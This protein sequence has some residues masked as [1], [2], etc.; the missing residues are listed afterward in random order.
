MSCDFEFVTVWRV[1]GTVAEVLAVLSDGRTLPRWWPSVYLDV[2]L[3]ETGDATDHVGSV[4]DLHTKGWLPYTLR[5]SLTLTEPITPTGFAL[6]AAGDLNGTGRWTFVQDGPEVVITYDWRVSAAKPLLRRFSWLLRPAFAANHRWAMARGEES[7]RL[8]VRRRRATTEAERAAVPPPP[9]PTFT[10]LLP[11]SRPRTV[12]PRPTRKTP[13]APRQ[14][15]ATAVVV[16]ASMAGLCAARVLSERF[17]HVLVLD[18][19]ALPE[20]P[21]PRGQVPQGRHPHLLLVAGARL[22]EGWFPGLGAELLA[23]GATDVDVCAD[24]YWHQSGGVSRRPVS[25]L[26]GPAMSRPFLEHAVRRRVESLPNVTV[27]GKT[28][29]RG[30]RLDP[31]GERITDV[32]LADGALVPCGLVIDATGRSARS[33]AWLSDLGFPPPPVS[34]VQIDTRYVSRMYSRGA[35]LGRDWKAAAVIDDPGAKRMAS[36]FPIEGDRALVTFAGLNGAAP[37]IEEGERRAWARSLPSP[38]VAEF[39]ESAEPLGA[40]VTHRFP[41]N[42]RRRVER[43]RRFPLGWLPLGDA[44]CSFDP[45]YGQGMSSAALQAAAMARCLDRAVAIDGAFARRY[46]RA[47]SRTVA[48]PWSIAVGADFLYDGTTGHKPPGTDLLNRYLERARIAAQHDDAVAIGMVEVFVL[49]RPPSALVRPG[50]VL[51][52]LR[53]ARRGPVGTPPVAGVPE[54]R[55]PSTRAPGVAA[56]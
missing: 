31:A 14:V 6:S 36:V 45:I 40:P 15:G 51:R 47:V 33:V 52:V 35:S 53:G 32:E 38:V 5:W 23:A 22:L 18:R 25:T 17:D 21:Q 50:F 7:L 56:S 39:M 26:R 19:D 42:Q 9:G 1:P 11:R 48:V 44:V 20:A 30:L 34:V 8:E 27:R 12:G 24:V 29:V 4:T 46:F 13:P 16:G 41:A 54:P 3:R 2:V 37:P 10:W 49:V 28:A 55:S 43:M